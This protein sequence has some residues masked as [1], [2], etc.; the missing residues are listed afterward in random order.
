MRECIP[1]DAIELLLRVF[2]PGW[3]YVAPDAE[4]PPGAGGAP[5]QAGIPP[6]PLLMLMLPRDAE[7]GLPLAIA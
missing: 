2:L 7:P 5:I 4:P 3:L 1:A 6:L